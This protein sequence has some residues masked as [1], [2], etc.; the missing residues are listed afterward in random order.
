MLISKTGVKRETNDVKRIRYRV[1]EG[2]F[3]KCE[4]MGTLET[5]NLLTLSSVFKEGRNESHH[6]LH[7]TL[8]KNEPE[9]EEKLTH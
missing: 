4:Y 7:E 2:K 3:N 9:T 5:Q 1:G 6:Y 8:G